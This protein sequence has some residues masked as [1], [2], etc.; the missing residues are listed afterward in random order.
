MKNYFVTYFDRNYLAKGLALIESLKEHETKD[1]TIFVICLDEITR[2]LLNK[3]APGNVVAIPLDAIERADFPLLN[4]KKTRSTVEYYWTL[5]PTIILRILE[6]YPEVDVLT[7]LDADLFFYAPTDAI[8]AELGDASVLIHE[9]RYSETLAHLEKMSGR[10]NV[11]LLCFR[12]DGKAKNVLLKWR[13]QCL[14][15]CYYRFE[16]GRMGDQMYLDKWPEEYDCV[17]ILENVGAGLAPWNHAKYDIEAVDNEVMVNE[18]PLVFYHFHAF[19]I[20][21]HDL[22]VPLKHVHYPVVRNV[23][24]YIV[25]P[26][27]GC[28]FDIKQK[29][30]D[31]L[32]EFEFG[33]SDEL[34]LSPQH[35]LFVKNSDVST[36]GL[37]QKEYS[38]MVT[39]EWTVLIPSTEIS[40]GQ[41]ASR[42]TGRYGV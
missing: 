36:L 6:K 2:I 40:S 23:N 42:E 35:T 26:Y 25:I 34:E 9:H 1:F 12:N 3:L 16:E 41:E 31:I 18:K 29:I 30:Q 33:F 37:P 17:R 10:F 11:G 8:Y 13:E 27:L 32:P 22:V 28:L 39:G 38:H 15:W 20:L 24:Q 21:P 5:T 19:C 7:Y 14:E 4:A